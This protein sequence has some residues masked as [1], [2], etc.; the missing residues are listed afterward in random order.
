M[1][2]EYFIYS[3]VY[4]KNENKFELLNRFKPAYVE[5]CYDVAETMYG[6]SFLYDLYE[7]IRKNGYKI[8]T[9]NLSHE[10]DKDNEDLEIYEI[11]YIK[12]IDLYNK[13]KK[14]HGYVFIDE[15]ENKEIDEY[16]SIKEY[17]KI[18]DFEVK[19]KLKY[20][21]WY[22]QTDLANSMKEI[23]EHTKWLLYDYNSLNR[24]CYELNDVRFILEV[25]Y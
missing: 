14:N 25:S 13:L 1:G 9:S 22:V 8:T 6:K 11:P 7:L 19:S 24:N 16:Y 18:T 10:L 17:M 12:F 15:L 21:E 5:D 2:T 23:I 3:E 20:H 4:N